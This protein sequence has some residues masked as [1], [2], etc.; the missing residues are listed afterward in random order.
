MLKLGRNDLCLCGSGKK[1]KKCCLLTGVVL[2]NSPPTA[3]RNKS[4]DV[5]DQL[6]R[7]YDKTDLIKTIASLQLIPLNHGKNV[8]LEIL[9]TEIL[10]QSKPADLKADYPT[11][12]EFFRNNFKNH[13][14]DDPVSSFFTENVIFFGGNFTVFPGLTHNGSRILNMYLE[15]IFTLPN[16]LS[17]DFKKKIHDGATM[18]LSIGEAMAIH[19]GL[20]RYMYEADS[21]SLIRIPPQN[22]LAR[23]KESVTFDQNYLHGL[24]E[25][26]SFNLDIILEFVV[27]ENDKELKNTDPDKNPLLKYPLLKNEDEYVF[28]L[29]SAQVNCLLEFIFREALK[30]N[31]SNEL[32][33]CYYEHQWQRIRELCY[34]KGWFETD[35]K[36]PE[37]NSDELDIKESI[38]QFDNDKLAY[39][40]LIKNGNLKEPEERGGG[41]D[42]F[43]ET[44]KRH[45]GLVS[46]RANEV[47]AHLK[48]VN[49][50][51]EYKYFS[52]FI[53]GEN[54][55]NFYFTFNKP[56][57]E[58]QVIG[59]S[60]GDFEKLFLAD[61]VE[62]LSLWKFAKVRRAA[63]E[64]ISI[65]A[66]NGV[67]DM[68][69]F[70]QKNNQSLLP[71]DDARP[72]MLHVAVGNATDFERE[73]VG[74]RDEHATLQFTKHGLLPVPVKR[75]RK[76]AP[77]Y[78][79][80][81]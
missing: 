54:G 74:G 51:V 76:F 49:G 78:I 30:F 34:E 60:F 26:Y 18:M 36:L 79:E 42:S 44:L 80:R 61:E 3:P 5:L 23:L 65:P 53:S 69:S 7:K 10:I 15:S 45:D 29:P 55:R 20:K 12:S 75:L 72:T 66:F 59:V 8:R 52:V 24:A 19:A 28:V 33:K 68:F 64:T 62:G 73:I 16:N 25:H 11:L 81:E 22:Y 71:S 27:D 1:Y 21:E 77:I 14:L 13:Y 4:V 50:S 6:L 70:Y 2:K 56:A 58:N 38:F 47:L 41:V 32:L 48:N 37:V 9:A 17:E 63:S 43:L 31:C 35:I 46:K 57:G 67:L 39:V 40:C